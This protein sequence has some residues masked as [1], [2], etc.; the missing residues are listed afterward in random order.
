[1]RYKNI[2]I[3]LALSYIFILFSAFAQEPNPS[4]TGLSLGGQATSLF[5]TKEGMN[6]R[7][8]VPSMSENAPM[9]TLDGSKEFNAK[10]LCPGSS[11]FMEIFVQPSA[12]GDLVNVIVS[13]DIDMNGTTDY[14]FSVPFAISGACANGVMS[15][16]PGTWNNCQAYKWTSEEDGKVSL[17]VTEITNLGGCYCINSSCGSN[18]VWN[19]LPVVLRSLGGG[20]AGA[21]HSRNSR[22]VI[23]DV[24]IEGTLARYYGQNTRNCSTANPSDSNLETYYATPGNIESGV[25]SIVSQQAA[26]PNSLYSLMYN[27]YQNTPQG[28]VR[29]CSIARSAVIKWDPQWECYSEDA[30]INQCETH[31]NDPNCKLREETVDG[32]VVFRNFSST[33]LVPVA[34]CTNLT[35]TTS[36]SCEYTCPVDQRLPCSGD[37]PVCNDGTSNHDCQTINPVASHSGSFSNLMAVEGSG[38]QLLFISYGGGVYVCPLGDY[39]CI[40]DG[41]NGYTCTNYAGDSAACYQSDNITGEITFLPGIE[42]WGRADLGFGTTDFGAGGGPGID[43]NGK[44][45]DSVMIVDGYYQSPHNQRIYFKGINIVQGC[46]CFGWGYGP[47]LV[48]P[49]GGWDCSGCQIDYHGH[50]TGTGAVRFSPYVCPITGG[51]GCMGNPGYCNKSCEIQVCK[52]WWRKNRT[53]LCV[54][55]A[56]DFSEIQKRAGTITQSATKDNANLYYKDYTGGNYSDYNLNISGS[57]TS[58][59]EACAKAC[60]TKRPVRN[61]EST[62]TSNRTQ[63]IT[64]PIT[65]NF[66]Y[67][68]CVND[69][70][71][72]DSDETIVKNCQCINDFAEAST[73]MQTLRMGGADFICSSGT[74]KALR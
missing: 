60:K 66:Y 20:A 41:Y 67:K 30:T 35:N 19:N 45:Y 56:Y 26:D 62:L 74:S 51:S 54:T 58:T 3:L 37:P 18:L 49:T 29:T 43:P 7:M 32:V 8:F 13:Q 5:G 31:D 1:V 38:N 52:D 28:E 71:P 34:S 4:L 23:S 57:Y 47:V 16:T 59:T 2:L 27:T 48:T 25:G 36:A 39:Q 11:K 70:C 61:T 73:I 69:I 24:K 50:G 53:Y 72:V 46:L 22:I 9:K 10:L 44:A 68:E 14:S 21:I 55:Q 42:V 64:N 65:Y 33:G 6:T 40:Y 12:S 63:Y 15:C 17:A